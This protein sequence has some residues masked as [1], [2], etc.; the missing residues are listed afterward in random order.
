M[1]WFEKALDGSGIALISITPQ[2]SSRLY[3]EIKEVKQVKRMGCPVCRKSRNL[4]P[5]TLNSFN[6]KAFS[7][8]LP[9]T[10]LKPI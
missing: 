8:F 6:R 4:R 7:V 3:R 9:T 1:D 2:I 10:S 5:P